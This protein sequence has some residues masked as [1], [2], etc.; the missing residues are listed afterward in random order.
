MRS[1]LLSPLFSLLCLTFP[2]YAQT[3]VP[4]QSLGT[5]VTNAGGNASITGGSNAGNNLFHSFQQFSIP[6][7]GSATFDLTNTPQV[8]TV[9]SR[10]TGADRSNIDGLLRVTNSTNP[11]SLFLMNPNGIVFGP[12]A[13]LDLGGSFVGTTADRIQFKDGIEFGKMSRPILSVNLP[14]GLQMGTAP[15]AIEVQGPGNLLKTQNTLLAPYLPTGTSPGLQVYPGNTLALVG[16]NITIDGGILTAP[17][18]RVE[19]ASL[20]AN[21]SVAIDQNYPSVVL[22]DVLGDRR[23]IQF[24]NKALVDVNGVDSGSIQIQGRQVDLISGAILWIQSQN[25]GGQITINATDRILADGTSPD[26]VEIT[27]NGPVFSTVSGI[28]DETLGGD[29]GKISL[30][31]PTITVQN[32]ASIMSRSFSSGAGGDL[33]INAKNINVTGVSP[34]LS[35]IFS[36]I[37]TST[38]ADGKGGKIDLTTQNL[39]LLNGGIL[40]ALTTGSG[41]SGDV[42]VDADTVLISGLSPTAFAS[43]LSVP[44]LGGQGKAGSIFINTRKLVIREGGALSSVSFGPGNA[45]SININASESIEVIGFQQ[46]DGN[47]YQTG[48]SSAVAPPLEPYKSLFNLS[49]DNAT[50]D[51]G[52]VMVNTRSLKILNRGFIVV[53]NTG[54][55]SAGILD[56]KADRIEVANSGFISASS[57]VGQGGNIMIHSTLLLLRNSGDILTSSVSQ[58]GG[59]INIISNVI[60]GLRDS[61]I[62]ASSIAGTGGRIEITTQGLF[63]L[64]FRNELTIDNDI[65]ASSQFGI[66]GTVQINSISID[67]SAALNVL[68]A[69]F[70]N[71]AKEISN[72]CD[73]PTGS[74]FIITGHG[75]LPKTPRERFQIHRS[76]GDLRSPGSTSSLTPLATSKIT[77]KITAKTMPPIVEASSFQRS[78]D[79]TIALVAHGVAKVGTIVASCA[80][81]L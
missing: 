64:K 1:P 36:I 14:I 43:S 11:V 41:N 29:G 81:P 5:V 33:I 6:T 13:T 21:A 15:G 9:F 79:G 61:D 57:E 23:D 76:W 60:V 65:T 7:G 8:T 62:I 35:D 56:L 47:N 34:I 30:T 78:P 71:T 22:G 74:R 38:A 28:I 40:T 3:I 32:G 63:G 46:Q 70:S 58:N 2:V 16:G 77:S 27:P 18:G 80:I 48:I 49:D 72:Q 59:N 45:G 52:N 31:V 66:S 42:T 67:P 20:G 24:S 68:P 73:M 54:L 17:G 75:G 10:I 44:T 26:L 4:D 55:G 51:S 25:K 19:L 12:N 69:D 37:G 50:G 53:E 39:S